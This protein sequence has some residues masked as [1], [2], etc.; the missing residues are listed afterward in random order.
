MTL[1]QILREVSQLHLSV[2][3]AEILILKGCAA[4]RELPHDDELNTLEDPILYW[5]EYAIE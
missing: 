4:A 5:G 1:R 2:D 3:E